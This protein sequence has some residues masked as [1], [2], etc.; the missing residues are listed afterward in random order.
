MTRINV[1][2][3]PSELCDQHLVAE[4]RE[5]PRL[6]GLESDSAPPDEFKLGT[7]HVLWCAQYQGMLADRYI[8][9]VSEMRRRGFH[10]SYPEPPSGAING[11]RPKANEIE[12]ARPIVLQRLTKKLST[13]KRPPR[14]TGTRK[15]SKEQHDTACNS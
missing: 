14:W 7:G 13:M 1:G 8:G 11:G 15:I 6:W 12:A 4:Y 3:D 10:V 5:L 9:L 2:I